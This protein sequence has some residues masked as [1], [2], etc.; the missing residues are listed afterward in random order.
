MNYNELPDTITPLDYA[1]WSNV[2]ENTARETFNSKG[3]PRLPCTGTKQL[4]DKR[5]VFLWRLGLQEDEKDKILLEMAREL[6]RE[7]K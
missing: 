3:F 1:K 4:A 7:V 6:I 2:G 5:A